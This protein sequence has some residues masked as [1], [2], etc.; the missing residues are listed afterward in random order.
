MRNVYPGDITIESSP[1]ESTGGK[2]WNASYDFFKFLQTRLNV[3]SAAKCRILELGSGCGW[4]GIRLAKQY[5]ACEIVMSE[6]SNFGALDWLRYNI[7]LNGEVD[8]KAIEL[9]WVNVPME[10]A[11]VSWDYVIGSELVYSYEGA[12]LLP[13]VLKA[14]LVKPTSICFY[15]HSLNRFESIDEAL[16]HE[17]TANG[18]NV[19]V[20]HGHAALAT[21]P[22]TY[23]E[24]FPDMQL[25]IFKIT[26]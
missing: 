8:T 18:L 6:Q 16:L 20:V 5:P 17:F 1:L 15:A 11:A 21:P 22:G 10:V 9:D 12:R 7:D 13:R 19:E 24:L 26:N 23:T 14:L 2:V 3:D 4:L 25:V